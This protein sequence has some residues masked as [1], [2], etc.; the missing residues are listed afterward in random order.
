MWYVKGIS[1]SVGCLARRYGAFRSAARRSHHTTRGQ[2]YRESAERAEAGCSCARRRRRTSICAAGRR[3]TGVHFRLRRL[4]YACQGAEKIRR[5]D[6]IKLAFY[7]L[8][9]VTEDKC[10]KER[11]RLEQPTNG[12][13]Q[14]TEFSSEYLVNQ[15]GSISVPI[16]GAFPAASLSQEQLEQSV[17]CSFTA[18]L[19]RKGFVNI[20][21]I[22]RQ[23]VYVVGGVK[24]S[25]GLTLPRA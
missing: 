20:L 5:G 16:L 4:N 12:I 7:E 18:F 14:G 24:N 13:Q 6:P 23:P 2:R 11:Q 25:G 15:E 22:T 17:Q 8:L 3:R 10:G 21:N 19:G 1:P 9:E